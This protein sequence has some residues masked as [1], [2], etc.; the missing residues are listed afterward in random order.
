MSRTGTIPLSNLWTSEKGQHDR[1][2][3]PAACELPGTRLRPLFDR[4]RG[5]EQPVTGEDF[6]AACQTLQK[7]F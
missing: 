5:W 3:C 7:D 4:C 1:P 6:A 2:D